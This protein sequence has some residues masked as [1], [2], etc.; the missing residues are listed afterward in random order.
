M[1][2][3]S[4]ETDYFNWTVPSPRF[5]PRPVTFGFLIWATKLEWWDK[6]GNCYISVLT[7][8]Q[9]RISCKDK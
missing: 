3:Y 4:Y 1:I 5:P 6:S 7:E 9:N 2:K 8:S